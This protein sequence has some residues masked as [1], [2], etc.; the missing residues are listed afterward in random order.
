[1]TSPPPSHFSVTL[2]SRPATRL[3]SRME[4][5]WR[6]HDICKRAPVPRATRKL[7]CGAPETHNMKS[8]V[9]GSSKSCWRIFT[10]SPDRSS[11]HLL[12]WFRLTH[13]EALQ[14]EIQ[15]WS[16]SNSLLLAAV[17]AVPTPHL[18]VRVFPA[19]FSLLDSL[20]HATFPHFSSSCCFV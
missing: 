16:C 17:E 18:C 6:T 10:E 8:Q 7:P 14:Q 5:T 15:M 12:Q 13:M 20:T 3:T 2:F 4:N 9:T 19:S 11:P 1:M